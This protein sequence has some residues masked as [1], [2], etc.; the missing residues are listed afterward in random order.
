MKIVLSAS[1]VTHIL[2]GRAVDAAPKA[3][4]ETLAQAV[5][6]DGVLIALIRAG[7]DGMWHPVKV[8]A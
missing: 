5:A 3:P 1:Q 8:F 4:P 6:A 7:T 2:H